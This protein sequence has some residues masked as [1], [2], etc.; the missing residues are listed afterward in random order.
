[1]N[2][3][4]VPTTSP[5]L[6]KVQPEGQQLSAEGLELNQS[7]KPAEKKEGKAARAERL[8][9]ASTAVSQATTD[10]SAQP[11]IVP[12]GTND[13]PSTD[14]PQQSS[15]SLIADDVDVIEKVWVQKAKSIVNETK[16]DPHKQ[17]AELAN[18]KHDYQQKR[19]NKGIKPST[20]N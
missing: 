10:D 2:Q 14:Q 7:K 8:S 13:V 17:S 12:T 19:F 15:S 1:M 6:S 9:N 5:E 11:T 3:D 18:V 4:I 16:D 20:N